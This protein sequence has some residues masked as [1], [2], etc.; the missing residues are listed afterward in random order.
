MN[1]SM[2]HRRLLA[3]IFHD[4]DLAT[5]RPLLLVDVVAQHPERRP[6]SL[7]ARNLDSG[8]EAAIGLRKLVGGLETS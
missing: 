4:V 6:H 7:S 2:D 5:R 1:G 3:D 8:F